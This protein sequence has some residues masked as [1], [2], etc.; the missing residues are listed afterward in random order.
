MNV[1]GLMCVCVCFYSFLLFYHIAWQAV[2]LFFM[3]IYFY[4]AVEYLNIFGWLYYICIPKLNFD[5]G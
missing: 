5:F 1:Y 4:F 3:V 2:V